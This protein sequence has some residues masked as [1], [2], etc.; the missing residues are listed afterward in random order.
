M[1]CVLENIE[2]SM[3]KL[4]YY[5]LS[6]IKTTTLNWSENRQ[7]KY[8]IETYRKF[9]I[10]EVTNILNTWAKEFSLIKHC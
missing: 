2:L 5:L 4:G 6:L 3:F 1:D 9:D 7:G 10:Q 8:Q